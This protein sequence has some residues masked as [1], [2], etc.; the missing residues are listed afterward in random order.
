MNNIKVKTRFDF[1]AFK[2]AN[3]YILNVK[4]KTYLVSIILAVICLVAGVY[5]LFIS[6][7]D[8]N[9]F[10]GVAFLVLAALP[11]YSLLTISK[12]IDKSIIGFFSKNPSYNQYLEFTDEAVTLVAAHNGN[13]EKA[14]YDWAYV[15]EINVLKDY[16]L[17]F[18]NG[19]IP[20]VVSRNE[21]DVFEGTQQDLAELL[22]EKG[23]LKPYRVYE[24]EIIKN[25]SDPI[26]YLESEDES[27]E[28]VLAKFA[29]PVVEAVEEVEN[30]EELQETEVIEE[31]EVVETSEEVEVVE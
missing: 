20:L 30:N 1:K 24:K 7:E 10:L 6:K 27:L 15:Q 3:L 13:L 16:Y 9:T 22:K 26:N 18:L 25:F 2:T 11:I 19:N 17:L 14:V 23:I 4:K 31:A 8:N 29:E 21:D 28:E 5:S 12:K